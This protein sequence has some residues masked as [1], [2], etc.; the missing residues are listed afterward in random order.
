MTYKIEDRGLKNNDNS[1]VDGQ[2]LEKLTV[3]IMFKPMKILLDKLSHK[4]VK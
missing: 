2:T 4:M 3:D 1:S